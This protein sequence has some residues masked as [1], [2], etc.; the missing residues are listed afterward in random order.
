M[1]L[2]GVNWLVTLHHHAG[3]YLNTVEWICFA[4]TFFPLMNQFMESSTCGS[5]NHFTMFNLVHIQ[6]KEHKLLPLLFFLK[7]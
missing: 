2:A 6:F 3:A 1:L 7:R 5:E 4:Y